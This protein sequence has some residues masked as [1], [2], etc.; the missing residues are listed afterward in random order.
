MHFNNVL[1]L[2]KKL[3]KLCQLLI[4]LVKMQE[5]LIEV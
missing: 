3:R 1:V 5:Q 4:V 2:R